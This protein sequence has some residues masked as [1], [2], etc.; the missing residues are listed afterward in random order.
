MR[1]LSSSAVLAALLGLSACATDAPT[2]PTQPAP[3]QLA[4]RDAP[5][6]TGSRIPARR[7]EKMVGATSGQDYSETANAQPAPLRSN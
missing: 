1:L 2:T 3:Q 6:M 5:S 4:R 7:T